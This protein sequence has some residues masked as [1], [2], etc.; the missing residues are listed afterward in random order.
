MTQERPPSRWHGFVS[1]LDAAR[2][3]CSVRAEPLP[4]PLH[5]FANAVARAGIRGNEENPKEN[6]GDARFRIKMSV[7]I[8]DLAPGEFSG[9]NL[10]KNPLTEIWISA[11]T[12]LHTKKKRHQE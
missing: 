8:F 12:P 6:G 3:T 7:C 9:E 2:T 5:S 4:P 11:I 10:R 1:A